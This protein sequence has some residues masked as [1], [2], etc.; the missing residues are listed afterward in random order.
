MTQNRKISYHTADNKV[1]SFRKNIVVI[2]EEWFDDMNLTYVETFPTSLIK[3]EG[4]YIKSRINF[5]CDT[6][7]RI[8][9]ILIYNGWNTQIV[10]ILREKREINCFSKEMFQ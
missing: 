7:R 9:E 10:Q 8:R 6:K 4:K 5:L 3:R 1:K 2:E